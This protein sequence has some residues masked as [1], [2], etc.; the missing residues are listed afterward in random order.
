MAVITSTST[1]ITN[2]N[3]KQ[4]ERFAFNQPRMNEREPNEALRVRFKPPTHPHSRTRLTTFRCF[5]PLAQK[6]PG[7]GTARLQFC[8]FFPG[9]VNKFDIKFNLLLTSLRVCWCIS[10]SLLESK[11]KISLAARQTRE[12]ECDEQAIVVV[13]RRVRDRY[14][15]SWKS[16]LAVAVTQTGEGKNTKQSKSVLLVGN[17]P[18]LGRYE[19]F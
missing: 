9:V 19:W 8:R 12:S 7:R 3:K 1:T 17:W 4:G 6:L 14:L 13:V 16:I 11:A 5:I 18:F 15:S 2:N 10:T